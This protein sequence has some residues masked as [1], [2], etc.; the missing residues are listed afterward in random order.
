MPARAQA[1]ET[2]MVLNEQEAMVFAAG[3]LRPWIC[4]N[5]FSRFTPHG[6][7]KMVFLRADLG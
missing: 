3:L 4:E 6:L 1:A 7:R 5:S 2:E